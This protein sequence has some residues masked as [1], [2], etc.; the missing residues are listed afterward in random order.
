LTAARTVR[1][2]ECRASE[3][4]RTH[5]RGAVPRPRPRPRPRHRSNS[6]LRTGGPR[7]PPAY[8]EARRR[9]PPM[10]PLEC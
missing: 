6:R 3:H 4:T 7:V 1:R 5:S 8:L 9:R 10:R 2:S